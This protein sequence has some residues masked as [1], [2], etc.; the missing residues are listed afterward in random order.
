MAIDGLKPSTG[1]SDNC[2]RSGIPRPTRCAEPS[3]PEGLKNV[4]VPP[5]TSPSKI[6]YA[7]RYL[8]WNRLTFDYHAKGSQTTVLTEQGKA[9]SAEITGA[10]QELNL[11]TLFGCAPRTYCQTCK[12]YG[13]EGNI[14]TL[15]E[16]A[17]AAV[18]VNEQRKDKSRILLI[19]SGS[20]RFDLTRGPFTLDDAYIVSPFKNT[21]KYIPDVPYSAA[22]VCDTL[23]PKTMRLPFPPS[24]ARRILILWTSK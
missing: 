5:S 22:L 3:S 8:D 1:D 23:P 12:P 7:R 11:T 19:N 10:R 9:V 15:L 18:V 16:Q 21:F 6:K 24:S 14:N 20:T 13:V 4:T 2:P 17:L